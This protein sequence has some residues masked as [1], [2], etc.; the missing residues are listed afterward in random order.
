[1]QVVSA[2]QGKNDEADDRCSNRSCHGTGDSAADPEC[3]SNESDASE[4]LEH[5][6][7]SK[8]S[9]SATPLKDSEERRGSEIEWHLDGLEAEQHWEFRR[10]HVPCNGERCCEESET[11]DASCD[12]GEDERAPT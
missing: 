4:R 10:V 9:K 8:R 3:R 11:S 7:D 6:K 2:A 5:R 12:E 1:M